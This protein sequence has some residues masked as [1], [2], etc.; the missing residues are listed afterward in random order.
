MTERV[1]ERVHQN[2]QTVVLI[3]FSLSHTQT[4]KVQLKFELPV[5]I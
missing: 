3:Q 2:V 1:T 4:K 5:C